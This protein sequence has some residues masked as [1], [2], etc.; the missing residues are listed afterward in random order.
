MRY[1]RNSSHVKKYNETVSDVD[2][3]QLETETQ[4]TPP[5]AET[6]TPTDMTNDPTQVGGDT[7]DNRP[8]RERVTPKRFDDFVMYK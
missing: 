7:L 6:D 3:I 1:K 4:T 8:R 2:K 5:V